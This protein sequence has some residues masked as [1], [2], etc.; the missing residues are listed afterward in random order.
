[1]QPRRPHPTRGV[2]FDAV[3]I[4]LGGWIAAASL[5]QW[6]LSGALSSPWMLLAPLVVVVLAQ[7]PLIVSEGGGDAVIG[8]EFCVLVFLALLTSKVEAGALWA[9]G[10]TL[11]H[12][13]QR[14]SFRSR[15]FNVGVTNL[16]GPIAVSVL[17]RAKP[18]A[19]D[20]GRELFWIGVAGAVYFLLD[21]VI[22]GV[23][24]SAD[25][26]GRLSQTIPLMHV[27]V[28]LAC[29]VGIDTLGYLGAL[30]HLRLPPAALGLLLVPLGAIVV[31]ARALS[32]ARLNH[33]RM[34][35]LFEAASTASRMPD[36]VELEAAL[37]GHAERALRS[38]RVQ[39]RDSAPVGHE[40]GARLSAD[41]R[42]DR[43][44][45][46]R[47][48]DTSGTYFGE[49]DH[50]ALQALVAVATES[51]ERRRLVEEMAYLAQH[52]PLTG[53]G[54]RTV[55][56]ERMAHA[57]RPSRRDWT[58]PVV[59][60]ADLDGFKK[61][62]DRL[63]HATGDRLLIAVA[64]RLRSCTRET[65]TVARLGGDEFAVL[66]EECAGDAE[67][68]ELADRILAALSQ[69]FEVD[70]YDIR[71]SGSI[72]LAF[73]RGIADSA[74]LLRNADLALYRAKTRGRSRVE[75]FDPA[76]RRANLHRLDLEEELRRA[77]EQDSF[78]MHYQPIV[79]LDTGSVAGFEAL[80]RWNHP[81]LGP[82]APDVFIPLAEQIGLIPRLGE[83]LLRRAV[84]DGALL[85]A[86]SGRRLSIAV[87]VSTIQLAEPSFPALLAGI[88]E[89]GSAVRLVIELTEGTL[90]G[91][92]AATAAALAAIRAV[93]AC[94]S[95]DD[96]GVGYSSIAYLH[97]LTVDSLKIDKSFVLRLPDDQ[98]A[99]AL[100]E[101]VCAMARAL[102]IAVVAEGIENTASAALVYS[103]GC[104]TGQ[105][106]Y[107][108]PAVP[109]VAA[110]P[111]VAARYDVGACAAVGAPPQPRSDRR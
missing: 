91:E 28:P 82:I 23:S 111:L 18:V 43:Y 94:L 74:D 16:L 62:N 96:F 56:M 1:M 31:A 100:I 10:T 11:A 39:W 63:G 84:A 106:Y 64:D 104:R 41:G 17:V 58:P 89:S 24:L 75:T 77:L 40:I 99:A 3:V 65:D 33:R 52:D 78:E 105:G 51:L 72:G 44:L 45:I 87:N 86:A 14:K 98:R 55:L 47:R 73:G 9:I 66:V 60:Y 95:V 108:S 68:A 27:P 32:G 109:L 4:V 69:P 21:L 49:D 12:V 102:D 36:T 48:E 79:A 103:L 26:A 101:G 6:V 54:N 67:A 97:R 71:I 2:A 13:W 57:V 20:V 38:T 50:R 29:F 5:E 46:A 53:L 25:G 90:L 30:T 88:V 80:A 42:P 76:L 59:L 61:V 8:F 70:G 81:R 83:R 15:A 22:T 19:Q 37:V 110:L 34:I 85:S 7:F 92:D 107:F 35:G 93:G